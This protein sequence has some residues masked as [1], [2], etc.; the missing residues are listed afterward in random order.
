[1]P[2]N[3]FITCLLEHSTPV[4]VISSDGGNGHGD[5]DD[6]DDNDDDD[7]DDGSEWMYGCMDVWRG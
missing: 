5:D 1:M 6:D 7:D 4:M 2:F 3:T